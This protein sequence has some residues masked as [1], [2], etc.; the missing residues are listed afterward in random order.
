MA[1]RGS[2]ERLILKLF[3]FPFGGLGPSGFVFFGTARCLSFFVA[4]GHK[5]SGTMRCPANEIEQLLSWS[6]HSSGRHSGHP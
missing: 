5:S 3:S 1:T 2:I 6:R 4:T